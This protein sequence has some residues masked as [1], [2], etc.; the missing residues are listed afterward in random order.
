M[1]D[2]PDRD[3]R[4]SPEALLAEA[5]R[6]EAAKLGR[7]KLKIFLGPYP[8]VGKTYSML[9]AGQERRREGTDVVIGVVETHGRV[10]T[11]ALLHGFETIARKRIS[12]RGRV[13]AEMDLDAILWRKPKLALV[14]ELAHTNVP[15]SRHNKRWQ[16]VEEMLAAGIDVYTTL[17]VQHLESLNDVVAKISRVHVRETLPDKVL[18]LAEEIE[19]VD[20]PPDG[21]LKRLSEGKVYV[22]EQAGRAIRHFFSKGNLTAFRELA[23]RVAVERVDSDVLNYM[24]THA[25]PGPWPTQDRLMVCVNESPVSKKLIRAARRMA[26]R[27]HVPWLAVNVVTPRHMTLSEEAKEHTAESMRLAQS[28]GAELATLQAESNVA[29][30]ILSFA[31]NHNVTRLVMGRPRRRRWTGMLQEDVARSLLRRAGAIEVTVVSPDEPESAKTRIQARPPKLEFDVNA[32]GQ[33][34]LL[35]TIATLLGFVVERFLPLPNISLVYLT[36]VVFIATRFGLVPSLYTAILSFLCYNFFFTE[37]YYTLN[38][39]EE[40]DLLTITFFLAIAVLVGNLAARL[41][42][43]VEV[44]RQTAR[45]TQNLFDFSRK[46]AGAA[47]LDDVLWAAVHHVASTLECRSMVVMPKAEGG[48]GIAAAYPPEDQLTPNDW[49]AADWAWAHGQ[50]AGWGSDTLPGAS[51]LFLPLETQRGK[52]GLISISFDSQNRTLSPEQVHLLEALASQVAVAI[53]RTKLAEDIE[54]ARLVSETERLRSSLLTSI[55]HDLRTP[56]ASIIGSASS[57]RSFGSELDAAQRAELLGTIQEEAERLNRFIANLLDMTRLE[58]GAIEPHI[59]VVDFADVVGSALR[60]AAKVLAQHDVEIDIAPQLPMLRLDPVLFEQV[61]FNLLDNAAKYAPVGSKITLRAR[62]FDDKVRIEVMD[63][64]EGIPHENLEHIFDK[65][66][67]VLA[68]DR[69][70]A[71]TGL[72]LAISRG[73]IEALGGTISAGNRTDRPGALFSIV[74]PAS[75]TDAPAPEKEPAA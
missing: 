3:N 30:E 49:G 4:P 15:G 48:L 17:N 57:L 41:K 66:Y 43:Q 42:R 44:M 14:D 11:E 67:R 63:E 20:L 19:L 74:L 58:L 27:Q 55:S 56:L 23:L 72:G 26:D 29:D 47:S 70:R 2:R 22:R 68:A 69:V 73:F 62:A 8:G 16:D 61:L 24:R 51:W 28:L 18:E 31:S 64:G 54:E 10:E 9:Q 12:Y 36:G 71:G 33:A 60:R 75:G 45:R 32:Y 59:E 7:G 40:P 39:F 21:L 65:F 46:I 37:P 52:A 35:V 1:D 6:E 53:E 50:R 25:V 5:A 13:F 34:T 38:V